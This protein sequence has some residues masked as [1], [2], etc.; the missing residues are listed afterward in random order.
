MEREKYASYAFKTGSMLGGI[1]FLY[2]IVM[3]Y[4]ANNSSFVSWIYLLLFIGGL[5][6]S[7][8]NYRRNVYRKPKVK[9]GRFMAIGAIISLVVAFFVAVYEALHIYKLDTAFIQNML[10]D[11]VTQFESMGMDA[12]IYEDER[13]FGLTQAGY[14][15]FSFI[16]VLIRNIFWTLIVSFIAS[17]Q[18]ANL[19]DDYNQPND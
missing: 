4:I 3:F 17:R 5:L 19:P 6:W 11:F 15:F 10:D 7:F 12:S 16:G 9:F 13:M 2:Y 18:N 1:L 8:I 14:P